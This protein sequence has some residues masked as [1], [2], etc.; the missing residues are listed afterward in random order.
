MLA[1]YGHAD[2]A[3]KLLLQ[4]ESPS[5]LYAVKKGATSIWETW[6]GIREDG[7]VHDSLNHY[8]YGAVSGWLM[9]GVAGISLNREGL[10]FAPTVLPSLGFVEAVWES[11]AGRIASAWRVR[12]GRV[13][14]AFEIPEGLTAQIRLPDGSVHE[15]A[16]GTCEYEI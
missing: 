9:K 15:A 4:E 2:T 8:S 11:P 16:A 5:W 1:A 14:F 3:E 10:T 7:T 12:E 13:H 6:D